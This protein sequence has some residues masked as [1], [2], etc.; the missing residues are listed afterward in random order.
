MIRIFHC[1]LWDASSTGV[2]EE[3]SGTTVH[4]TDRLYPKL[5]YSREQEVT[6]CLIKCQHIVFMQ[7]KLTCPTI[8]LFPYLQNFLSVIHKQGQADF[9]ILQ[10]MKK[11]GIVGVL[12]NVHL[13]LLSL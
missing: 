8:I 9:K 3:F 10:K 6:E 2:G 5:L 4:I 13:K 12:C 7:I 1:E 11:L